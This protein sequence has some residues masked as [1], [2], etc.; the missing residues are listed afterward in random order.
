MFSLKW[1]KLTIILPI[2]TGKDLQTMEYTSLP[3]ALEML[4]K[5]QSTMAA[6]NHAMGVLSQDAATAA[7]AGS[8]EGRALLLKKVGK[9]WK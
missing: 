6:Y 4:E 8:W 1:V 3:Q 9:I 5:L 7:P 2:F